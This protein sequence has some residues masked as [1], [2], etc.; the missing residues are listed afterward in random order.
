MLKVKLLRYYKRLIPYGSLQNCWITLSDIAD[1]LC[2][3]IRHARN[4]INQ[5]RDIGWIDWHPNTGRGH[6][7]LLFLNYDLSQLE[8]LIALECIEQGL[9]DKAL[10]VLE[11]NQCR[12]GTLLK[13]TTGA[14]YK[15]GQLCLRLTYYRPFS[16]LLPHTPQKNSERFLLRQ[17][18]SCLTQCDEKGVISSQLSHH[19]ISEDNDQQW[20]FYL[21]PDLTFHNGE[22]INADVV[23]NLFTQLK[24]HPDYKIELEHLKEISAVQP[25]CVKFTLSEPDLSFPGLLSDIKYAIQPPEQLSANLRHPVIGSGFFQV[26][27]HTENTLY[28]SAFRDFYGSR[29]LPEKIAIWHVADETVSA[30]NTSQ[31]HQSY[32]G[33]VQLKLDNHTSNAA[34]KEHV[35]LEYGCQYLLFNLN[36][37]FSPLTS[38]QRQWL[39]T[40]LAPENIIQE[41]HLDISILGTVIARNLLHSWQAVPKIF[42]PKI[43][44]PETIKIAVYDQRDLRYY[45]EAITRLLEKQNVCCVVHYY[46]LVDIQHRA[47]INR[48]SEQI[49]LTSVNIDDNR[50]ISLFRWFYADPLFR[51]SLS[52]SKS[53][54]FFNN[55]RLI[56]KTNTIDHYDIKLE[57]L[58]CQ[59]INNFWI[60]PLFHHL[61]VVLFQDEIQGV[62]ISNWGWP[63]L[64][65]IWITEKS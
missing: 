33:K 61:Q 17:I 63:E 27:E 45:A 42:S 12:L 21:R 49:I 30:N 65:D 48:L 6:R 26:K 4:L 60:I 38:E 25:L 19:W 59:M 53:Q 50:P 15:E 28:L 5:M 31:S 47:R 56:R 18:Y 64:K 51:I 9:Y 37:A 8:E 44:L 39:S 62:S 41:Q 24:S 20:S 1:T 36:Q 32:V 52:N 14:T 43:T 23:S 7:S 29:A 35:R 3:T 10:A 11:E 2:T 54:F 57:K 40:Y 34:N 58:A 16:A 22:V 13:T 55:L 46:S